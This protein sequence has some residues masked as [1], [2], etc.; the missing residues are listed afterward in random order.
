MKRALLAAANSIWSEL[1]GHM[2]VKLKSEL[3]VYPAAI[4]V[5]TPPAL[6]LCHEC[7]TAL[8]LTSLVFNVQRPEMLLYK[9]EKDYFP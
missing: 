2:L 8:P 6:S 4:N 7:S 1:N 3:Y 5:P 9:E